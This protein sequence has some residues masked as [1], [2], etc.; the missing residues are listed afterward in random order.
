MIDEPLPPAFMQGQ[1]NYSNPNN[2][3]IMKLGNNKTPLKDKDEAM[4]MLY[5]MMMNRVQKKRHTNY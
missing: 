3:M 2:M 5:N 4:K 1:G